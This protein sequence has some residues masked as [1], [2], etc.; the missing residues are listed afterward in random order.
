MA[1]ASQKITLSASPPASKGWGG[2]KVDF[3]PPEARLKPD[4][5]HP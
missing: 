2:R 4:H 5:T 1:T 3:Y